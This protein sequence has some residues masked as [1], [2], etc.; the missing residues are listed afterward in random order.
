MLGSI[1]ADIVDEMSVV[2]SLLQEVQG[3]LDLGKEWWQSD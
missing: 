1:P 2:S 3:C